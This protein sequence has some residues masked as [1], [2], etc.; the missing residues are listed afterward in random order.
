MAG[1]AGFTFFG[2]VFTIDCFG[3]DPCTGGFAHTAGTAKQEGMSQLVMPDR[4]F[5]CGGYMRL[6]HNSIKRLWSVF[7]SG[8]NEF[9]HNAEGLN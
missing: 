6:T 2:L 8:N 3:Q 9:I 5:K 7:S 1:I 4:I